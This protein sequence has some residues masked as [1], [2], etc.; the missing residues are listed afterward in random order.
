MTTL[1]AGKCNAKVLVYSRVVGFCRPIEQ[2][3]LG[4][5]EEFKE[6]CVYKVKF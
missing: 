4:K 2:W 3:N 5:Q 1:T 6:R